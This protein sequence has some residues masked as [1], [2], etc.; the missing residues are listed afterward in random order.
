VADSD[1]IFITFTVVTKTGD[2]TLTKELFLKD[3]TIQKDSSQCYLNRGTAKTI[4]CTLEA[5]AMGLRKLKTNQAILHGVNGYE[6]IKIVAERNF[7]GQSETITRTRKFFR[8]PKRNALIMCDYDHS[9]DS[10]VPC[11]NRDEWMEAVSSV[12]PGFEKAAFV[13]T[14][15]TSSCIFDRKGNEL[16]GEGVGFHH[17]LVVRES[18]D[19]KRFVDVLFKRLWLA[20]YGYIYI[21]R[22]GKQ[23]E[24]TIFDKT[25]FSPER[26][27]F[28]AGA[29]CG[30]GLVQRLPDPLYQSGEILDTRRLPDLTNTEESEYQRLLAEAKEATRE[31]AER[32][33]GAYV[34]TEA[35]ELASRA[36]T[37]LANR[38][39][40]K[41]S[42]DDVL[43]LDNGKTLTVSEVLKEPEKHHLETL[44]DPLEP[45]QG[46]CKAK[47]YVNT[48]GS[49]VVHS[50]VHGGRS[51]RI[52]TLRER[53]LGERG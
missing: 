15:S 44:R 33:K 35:P 3:G 52:N 34:E 39:T 30:D 4:Q 31:R 14:P 47:L 38:M 20:G 16:R 36:K 1:G 25:V 21:S 28:V 10:G 49:L 11:L 18:S 8:Y 5:F 45:E 32:T 17:Y 40:G 50:F 41:L 27:D 29:V 51:Y 46:R 48:D 2:G 19:I 37:I 26:L 24:R 7:R 43:D 12:C 23:L 9:G 53:S 6:S 13:K 22:D 42:P